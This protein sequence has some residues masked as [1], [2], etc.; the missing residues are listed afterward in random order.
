LNRIRSG[1][2]KRDPPGRAACVQTLYRSGKLHTDAYF[3][4]DRGVCKAAGKMGNFD[5]NKKEAG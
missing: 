3:G 2:K 1:D 5:L 4:P